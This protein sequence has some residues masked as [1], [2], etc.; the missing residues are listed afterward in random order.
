[1]GCSLNPLVATPILAYMAY[2]LAHDGR[3]NAVRAQA[4]ESLGLLDCVPAIADLARAMSDRNRPGCA[5]VRD[6]ARRA[7]HRLLPLV[8]PSSYGAL[9]ARTEEELCKLLDF[10]TVPTDDLDL[11]VLQALRHIGAGRSLTTIEHLLQQ[12]PSVELR[13][14]AADVLPAVRERAA[15]ARD[16]AQLLRPADSPGAPA[17]VL[18]RPVEAAPSGSAAL[19]VRPVD[20]QPAPVDL[21]SV[22]AARSDASIETDL[23]ART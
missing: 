3:R 12:T 5:N 18:L 4:A 7:L 1:M 2:M 19:L 9:P 22:E 13:R 14:A 6:A 17:D 15:R 8:D 11:P 16:A 21:S 23:Q 20:E 10:A